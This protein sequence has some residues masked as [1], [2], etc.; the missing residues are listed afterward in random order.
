MPVAVELGKGYG[1]MHPGPMMQPGGPMMQPGQF[2]GPM[3]GPQT[4]SGRK[5]SVI[6]AAQ[7]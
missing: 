4:A 1:P 6:I 3:K 7:I 2:G 5:A